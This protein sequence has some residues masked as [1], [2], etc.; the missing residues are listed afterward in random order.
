[1]ESSFRRCLGPYCSGKW[2]IRGGVGIYHDWFTNGEL[3][4]ALR[5]NLPVYA[6]P[7]FLATQGTAPIFA[8]GTALPTHLA[9]HSRS[10]NLLHRRSRWSPG[11]QYS[12]GGTDPNLK[13]PR[14]LNYTIG[15]RTT[16]RQAHRVSANYAGSKAVNLPEGTLHPSILIMT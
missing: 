16:N 5:A 4:V 6:N 12:I 14:V 10:F 11:Q 2:A 13:E 8:V 3:T 9:T 15:L 1:M 7:T